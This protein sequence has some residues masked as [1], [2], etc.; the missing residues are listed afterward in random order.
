MTLQLTAQQLKELVEQQ[1]QAALQAAQMQ[2]ASASPGGPIAAPAPKIERPRLPPPPFYSGGAAAL[3]DWFSAMEQQINW[4]GSGLPTEASRLTWIGA[5]LQGAALDWWKT[6]AA[7]PTTVQEFATQLRARFQPVNSAETARA[8]LLALVQSKGG[9]QPYVDAFRRLLVRVPDMSEADRLFQFLR[10]LHPQI[11]TQIKVSGKK[12]LEEAIDVAVRVGSLMEQGASVQ[13]HR[14]A[15]SSSTAPMELDNIEGLEGETD[16]SEGARTSNTDGEAP[17]TRAEL[18]ELLNAM[19]QQRKGSPGRGGAGAGRGGR[20][21][22]NS[23][24]MRGLPQIPHLPPV[25]VQEYMEA[26]KCFGCGSKDHQSRK[27][28]KRKED[29]NGRVSWS[30]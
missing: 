30:N 23:H 17:V 9:V 7:K 21:G 12:T 2:Q 15:A 27:C 24:R 18:R 6:L 25:Q 11:A 22:P 8:K 1:V 16:G 14:A 10:G 19:Q 26:G 28:P 3:D 13:M 20:S 29:A 5:Y 4:Y